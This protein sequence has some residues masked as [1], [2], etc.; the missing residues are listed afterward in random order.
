ME[1]LFENR[2]IRDRS[3]MK[4]F[5]RR[6]MLMSPAAIILYLAC[7]YCLWNTI[8]ILYLADFFYPGYL[9]LAVFV[10]GLVWFGYRRNVNLTLKRDLELNNGQPIAQHI[11]VTEQGFTAHGINGSQEV[12]FN[13][14][15]KVRKTRKLILLITNARLVWVFPKA[16]FTRGTPDEFLAF[17]K[18][19]GFKV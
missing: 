14:I 4:D 12:T 11:V 16:S 6:S 2:Y 18:T 19:K 9:L 8:E 17:L 13:T 15:K 10:L 3:L 1:P 5:Y 7:L